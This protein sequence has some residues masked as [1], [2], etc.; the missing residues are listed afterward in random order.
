MPGGPLLAVILGWIC[1]LF[2]S[3]AMLLFM[4]TP[5]EGPVWEVIIGVIALL[6]LGE[7]VIRYSEQHRSPTVAAG[8]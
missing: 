4:Y 5:G 1:I 6:A 7:L 8:I 2:L 3:I